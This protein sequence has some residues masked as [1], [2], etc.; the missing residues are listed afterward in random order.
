MKIATAKLLR[1]ALDRQIAIAEQSD[2]AEIGLLDELEALD[3]A[4][5]EELK[6][7]IEAADPAGDAADR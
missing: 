2:A 3:D 6:A 4:A 5:G 1:D 7:A